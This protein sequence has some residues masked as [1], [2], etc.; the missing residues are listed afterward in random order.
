MKLRYKLAF[1]FMVASLII[2][3]FG[4][5]QLIANSSKK[6][7]LKPYYSRL[8]VKFDKGV[9][10]KKAAKIIGKTG[11]IV[12]S[13]KSGQSI[14]YTV[15]PRKTVGN[16]LKYLRSQKGVHYASP[17]YKRRLFYTPAD[18]YYSSA[19]WSLDAMKV[20]SAWDQGQSAGWLNN[21]LAVAVIDTGIDTDHPDLNANLWVNTD[22]V[23][24]NGV[25]D[26]ANGYIDDRNG[27]SWGAITNY[28]LTADNYSDFIG[29]YVTLY[30]LGAAYP[31][32]RLQAIAQ[33]IT[34]TGGKVKSLSF[35]M[36]RVGTPKNITVSL[37]SSVNNKP[38]AILGSFTVKSLDV[39]S[40]TEDAAESTEGDYWVE[41]SFPSAITLNSGAQYFI[42]LSTENANKSSYYEIY[43]NARYDYYTDGNVFL[44]KKVN[45]NNYWT[46]T[47][48]SDLIFLSDA[49]GTGIE[50]GYGHGTSVSGVIGAVHNSIGGAG[51]VPGARIMSLKVSNDSGYMSDS[52]IIEAINYAVDNGAKVINMSLGSS[53]YSEALEEATNYAYN[54]GVVVVAAAGNDGT[55]VDNYPASNK[56]VISVGSVSDGN[57][58]AY[59]S[60]MSD[61]VDVVAPGD[62]VYTTEKGDAYT[63]FSGTSAASPQVA[64]LAAL[65][66]IK[67][68]TLAPA[69]IASKIAGTATDMGSENKDIYYG[70]G[71]VNFEK[72][73][74]STA[75]STLSATLNRGYV[76]YGNSIKIKGNLKVGSWSPASVLSNATVTA[77][78]KPFG[79]PLWIPFYQGST[80][81]AGNIST[82]I[83]PTENSDVR[84]V[85][86]GNETYQR[87]YYEFKVK[88][89]ALVHMNIKPAGDNAV[90]FGKVSPLHNG[91]VNFYR[92]KNGRSWHKITQIKLDK[93][94]KY[95]LLFKPL[96]GKYY[97]R[98]SIPADT[99]HAMG[100]SLKKTYIGRM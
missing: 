53:V 37:M 84:L 23:A 17:D 33:S 55:L 38:D 1:T 62:D 97:Y 64:G 28:A 85:W 52:A 22:E 50:D 36:N 80:D 54:N 70:Y 73:F 95:R 6:P 92:S 66:K 87:A 90:V 18:P 29:K 45:S 13:Q 7:K 74:G 83:S 59:Y 72:A 30:T 88:V 32:Q 5:A 34:G 68:S 47:I 100:K 26:D 51:I 96:K 12:K 3:P 2:T 24:G 41:K 39:V 14:L 76:Y 11:S 31:A 25:D 71:L 91:K 43:A 15:K 99:D 9:N 98:T 57:E 93:N 67:D 42:V 35:L 69:A 27:Y 78:Y 82:G 4:S 94:G 65:L 49:T 86:D 21:N 63:A 81:L 58:L 46:E 20:S 89:R 77:S 8:L 56:N 61:K 40:L 10:S 79:F 44:R 60:T 48:K 19:Q 75:F 16:S